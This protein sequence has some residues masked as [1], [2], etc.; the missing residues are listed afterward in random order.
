MSSVLSAG[1]AAVA[2]A[3]WT[4]VV[5]PFLIADRRA[6]RLAADQAEHDL[7]MAFQA[8][9]RQ[10]GEEQAR[11]PEIE[12]FRER[13]AEITSPRMRAVGGRHRRVA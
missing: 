11:D 12:L 6:R 4:L 7:H 9:L 13:H 2:V 5:A 10:A 3:G 8:R 1:D